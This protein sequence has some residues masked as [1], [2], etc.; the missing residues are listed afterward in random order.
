MS[1]TNLD[2]ILFIL[3]LIINLNLVA[4]NDENIFL[5]RTFWASNPNLENV[6]AEIEDGNDPTELTKFGFDAIAYGLIEQVDNTIIKYLLEQEGNDVNKL[7]HDGRTYIFWAAYKGNLDLMKY[8]IAKGAKTDIVDNHGYS[9]LNFA[10]S[11]GQTDKALYEFIIEQGA[12]PS[13]EKNT[14]GANALLLLLP[15][16]QDLLF[17]SFFEKYGLSIFDT[18]NNGNGA[19]AYA[20]KKG[21][22]A[23]IELLIKEKV[24]YKTS[25][26][27]ML[28]A[29]RG[30][31][32]GYNSL[33]FFKY[34]EGIGI[35][36]NVINKEGKTPLHNLA[37]RNKDLTT[38]NYFISS[39]ANVNT[40]DKDGNTALINASNRNTLNAIKLLAS[41][42]K[43]INHK[44]KKGI[45]H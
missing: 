37:Y 5:D 39:G 4:Q 40:K 29:T 33:E 12:N 26:D 22:K 9:L 41:K 2:K 10:A 19:I 38:L 21:N 30:S 43:D 36:A 13:V 14:E 11:T 25:G 35:E 3:I 31:R 7:T 24:P 18:D 8:F 44:N 32:N 15:N 42:T 1:M 23:L 45:L 17:T 6:K 20:A 28:M 27:V 16:L 34:L